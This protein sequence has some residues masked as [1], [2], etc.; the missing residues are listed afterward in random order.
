[1]YPTRM[2]PTRMRL[3]GAVACLLLALVPGL[4]LN[5]SPRLG[6]TSRPLPRSS[7]T[8]VAS[9]TRVVVLAESDEQEITDL[10]LEDMFEVFEEAD[11]TIDGPTDSAKVPARETAE[12]AWSKAPEGSFLS[13]A[14]IAGLAA[15]SLG[16]RF[17]VFGPDG[18]SL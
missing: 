14:V 1:M 4:A 6:V 16:I 13:P 7:W 9:R 10:T 11:K 15:V 17:V 3:I 12:E 8:V 2:L 5:V 18:A